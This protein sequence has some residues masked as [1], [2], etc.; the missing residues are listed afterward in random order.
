[1][2]QTEQDQ[3]LAEL[4][5][6]CDDAVR[7]HAAQHYEPLQLIYHP[8]VG[9][10]AAGWTAQAVMGPPRARNRWRRGAGPTPLAAVQVL[11]DLLGVGR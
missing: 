11:A 6:R 8:A 3:Q 7:R 2:V 1:M 9:Q 4:A 5:Q 10:T